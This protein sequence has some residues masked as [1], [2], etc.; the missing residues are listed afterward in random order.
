MVG[1]YCCALLSAVS[2]TH[3]LSVSSFIFI[4]LNNK[5]SFWIRIILAGKND[6][7]AGDFYNTILTV[8]YTHL[9]KC[10]SQADST[11]HQK[12]LEGELSLSLIHIS[13]HSGHCV[14][15]Y[16]YIPT[17]RDEGHPAHGWSHQREHH[18]GCIICLLYTSMVHVERLVL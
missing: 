17:L 16:R 18:P 2:Y 9:G 3:L 12:L 11:G 4:L 6:S 8:S 14:W 5:L 7:L 1:L 15:R 10:A 13:H